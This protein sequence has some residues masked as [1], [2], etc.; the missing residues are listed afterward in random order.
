MGNI[1]ADDTL[2][3]SEEVEQ[4]TQVV[5]YDLPG[6]DVFPE[7]IAVNLEGRK[8]FVSGARSGSIYRGDIDSG[9]I[10]VWIPGDDRDPLT[11]V[12]LH[13][14]ANDRLWV[15]GGA[16]GKLFVFDALTAVLLQTFSTPPAADTFIN[17][18]VGGNSGYV[19]AT[20]SLRTLL[21]RVSP[22]SERGVGESVEAWLDL[23]GTAFES[24]A[25]GS[26][27][28]GIVLTPDEAHLLVIKTGTGQL[29]RVGTRDGRIE[30]VDL[31]G[32]SLVGGDGLVLDGQTLFVVRNADRE[33]DVVEL[34]HSFS[35]GRIGSRYTHGSF[36]FPTTAAKAGK[37]LLV[38]NSQFDAMNGGKPR[39]PFRI[40]K[41]RLP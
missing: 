20:D 22:G 28:N 37:E 33:I 4:L 25:K 24:R 17:D 7:G 14:D 30:E 23:S 12:G 15:A 32:D 29:F 13:L 19:Y 1:R 8:F 39:L 11:T 3:V 35:S 6:D 18:L 9:E 16:S 21:F 5:T 27:T 36:E 40:S 10:E 2:N 38:V 34:D 31:G 41:V 26:D